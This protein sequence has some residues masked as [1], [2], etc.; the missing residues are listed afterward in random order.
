LLLSS[1]LLLAAPAWPEQSSC[2]IA[3]YSTAVV[4][5]RDL[6][7]TRAE[8][9]AYGLERV[10]VTTRRILEHEMKDWRRKLLAAIYASNASASSVRGMALSKCEGN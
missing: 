6:G 8:A 2:P 1:G 10:D 4:L 3:D 5:A 9:D 7:K